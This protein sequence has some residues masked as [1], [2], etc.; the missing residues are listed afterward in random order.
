MKAFK[1]LAL[2]LCIALSGALNAQGTGKHLIICSGQSNMLRLEPQINF[3]PLVTEAFNGEVIV[4]DYALGGRPIVN[5]I[6][7]ENDP[8]FTSTDVP[9]Y[10]VD[11]VGEPGILYGFLHDAIAD[12]IVGESEFASV[13]FVWMQGEADTGVNSNYPTYISRDYYVTRF[14][15]LLD[16][17]RQDFGFT[18][19]NIVIGRVSD[20]NIGANLNA[21]RDLQVALAESYAPNSA[22][23]NTDDLNTGIQTQKYPEGEYLKDNIHQSD[24]GYMIFGERL[25]EAAIRII[26][27]A[28]NENPPSDKSAETY[29]NSAALWPVPGRIEAENFDLR[30]LAEFNVGYS[31][32]TVGNNIAG[33]AA[34]AYRTDDDV[35]ILSLGG[36]NYAVTQIE[37]S[38]WLRYS[39]DVQY[40]GPE[41]IGMTPETYRLVVHAASSSATPGTVTAT[42]EGEEV[43]VTVAIENTGADSTF[44]S[45]TSA[46]F[47]LS[48]GPEH[49]KIDFSAASSMNVDWIELEKVNTGATFGNG[50]EL[51]PVPGLIEAENFDIGGSGVG[52]FDDSAGN[53]QAS[54]AGVYRLDEDVDILSLGADGYAVTKID[55][56]EWL[57]YSINIQDELLELAPYRLV[58]NAGSASSSPGSITATFE[59]ANVSVQVA[60][61]STATN[62]TFE[63]FKSATF[64]LPPGPDGLKI[65]FSAAGSM[66]L[67]WIQLV[68]VESFTEFLA[69]HPELTGDDTATDADPDKDG[70][71]NILEQHFGTDPSV[72][73]QAKYFFSVEHQ[74]GGPFITIKLD[75]DP[76]G[77]DLNLL[78]SCDLATW[79]A[80]G[81]DTATVTI[82]GSTITYELQR[83]TL[84]EKEFYKLSVVE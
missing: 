4:A 44:A 47:L 38:E 66:N 35:D 34:G 72:A 29:G 33:G 41:E 84:C 22:W 63:A 60:I 83:E 6:K 7:P 20:Y 53:T 9:G 3:T 10:D 81:L 15:E 74:V 51:W 1:P 69:A 49:L 80:V 79:D 42:L 25:A 77:S 5:W 18:D 65:D 61:G 11:K 26:N 76:K 71:P 8:Y 27:G 36:A 46:P 13:T 78:E 70:I 31:D 16:Q 30:D 28:S 58:V 19:I 37:S 32:S 12:K 73:N 57:K 43:T 75:N 39:I 45:F 21:M 14:N 54:G 52:Y 48:P 24:K 55:S 64:L 68:R 40:D 17:L 62:K 59:G 56:T 82:E 67:D 2:T 23:V 50:G